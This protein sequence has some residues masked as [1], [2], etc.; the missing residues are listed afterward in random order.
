MFEAF[1]CSHVPIQLKPKYIVSINQTLHYLENEL[2]KDSR[3]YIKE[4]YI[5]T[6][7]K[8]LSVEV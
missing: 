6:P 3:A 2:E 1:Q 8:I 7:E 5:S 4:F